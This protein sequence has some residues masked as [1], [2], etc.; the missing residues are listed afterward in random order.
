MTLGVTRRLFLT[1][2]GAMTALL[3]VSAV[4]H[5]QS[6]ADTAGSRKT[7][8]IPFVDAHRLARVGHWRRQRVRVNP[9]SSVSG[10]L[11]RSLITNPQMESAS[12]RHAAGIAREFGIRR[13]RPFPGAES[14]RPQSVW[15][16]RPRWARWRSTISVARIRTVRDRRTHRESLSRISSFALRV[17]DL[18]SP[19]S[20]R[21]LSERHSHVPG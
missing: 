17:W 6:K 18:D 20:V 4:V 16:G 10:M 7:I 21:P 2:A 5:G 12:W 9:F 1:T 15:L 11:R 3:Y 13:R 14:Y 8:S 19:S